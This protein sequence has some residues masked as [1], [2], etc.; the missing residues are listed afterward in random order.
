[1][2]S[3]FTNELLEE[4][5]KFFL[6]ETTLLSSLR[7]IPQ[8]R[9]SQMYPLFHSLMDT[10]KSMAVLARHNFIN[11]M[12][13]VSR[14]YIERLINFLYLQ[15]CD[16][17]EY[18]K[19]TLHATQKAYRRLSRS[20]DI[21]TGSVGL[22]FQGM[23]SVV[24]PELEEALN[25]FTSKS[26]KEI[27]HWT[28]VSLDRRIDLISQRT[29]RKPHIMLLCKLNIY[30][31]ASEALHGTLYGSVFHLGVFTPNTL[32]NTPDDLERHFVSLK[33]TIFWTCGLL[34]YEFFEILQTLY[35][36]LDKLIEDVRAIAN[37]AISEIHKAHREAA[38][39]RKS[40]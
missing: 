19:F 20:I 13:M 16:E 25:A 26:G 38:S 9:V 24:L 23:D 40:E 34:T 28:P 39:T 22:T 5:E 10:A 30:E 35:H 29:S 7:D 32:L 33:T 17:E 31:D 18:R 11:E 4:M 14:S 12:Y 1:M 8:L 37:R 27:T 2:S 3:P 21:S 15:V 6:E 36:N